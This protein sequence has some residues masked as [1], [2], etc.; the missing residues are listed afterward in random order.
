MISPCGALPCLERKDSP[1]DNHQISFSN[2]F[3]DNT[4]AAFANPSP[5]GFG[6]HLKRYHKSAKTIKSFIKPPYRCECVCVC[7]CVCVCMYVLCCW[8]QGQEEVQYDP[9]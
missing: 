7:V 3:Q 2:Q 6:C 1:G 4:Q 9:E 8:V 5:P